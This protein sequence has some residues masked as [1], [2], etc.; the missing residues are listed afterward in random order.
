MKIY[1]RNI[2]I[3]GVIY[4]HPE[5]SDL[6]CDHLK[7]NIG[8]LK[9]LLGNRWLPRLK[10]AVIPTES[11]TNF[12]PNL[13]NSLKDTSSPFHTVHTEGAEILALPLRTEN[14]QAIIAGYTLLPRQPPRI[15]LQLLDNE[16][17]N[18]ESY[19]GNMLSPIPVKTSSGRSS[20]PHRNTN[21]GSGRS[22]ENNLTEAK[23]KSQ[24]LELALNELEAEAK[25]LRDQ[26]EQTRSEYASLRSE[27]QLNDN[28]EQSSIVQ[29]LKDLNRSI[30][31]L[32]RSIAEHMFDS[33]IQASD[34]DDDTTLAASN[35]PQIK[36]QFCHQEGVTSLVVS[37]TGSGM[38]I[39]DF[40]DLG[41]RSIL[42]RRLYKNIFLPFHPTLVD[43]P[44]NEFTHGLY[45][46]V[47]K[48]EN[49]TIAAKW[50]ANSFLALSKGDD[51]EIRAQYV[52]KYIQ[53]ITTQD[54]DV[55]F[56][57]YFGENI[58]VSLSDS[59]SKA[60]EQLFSLA[61]GWNHTLKGGVVMLG[62]FMPVVYES[63]A[64]F[65]PTYMQ[66]FEPKKKLKKQPTTAL[67]TVGL[68]LMLSR[69]RAKG[70][71]P[72]STLVCKTSVVTELIY[73]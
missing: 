56:T 16:I 19:I 40:F 42:C 66:D 49:Q 39:E 59:H 65:D 57:G 6:N 60:L 3:T 17:R 45:N 38:P 71:S 12:D 31:N 43:D 67:C 30:E 52:R 24:Y 23:E 47:R 26:L 20:H 55:L 32:G 69:S 63:G 73:E 22:V 62:D 48:Q 35:L 9:R 51:A 36:A 25:H 33:Y 5:A 61:W 58:K 15:Q 21:R 41:V 50:R 53:E 28:T 68:G 72:D 34:I 46:E 29:S 7:Q 4:L 1:E 13:L 2:V 14:I 11:E 27:L 54:L 64:P 18:L 37:S 10:I 8:A 44:R 70:E